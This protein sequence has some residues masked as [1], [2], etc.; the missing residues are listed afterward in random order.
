MTRLTRPAALPVAMVALL[1]AVQPVAAAAAGTQA[2]NQ[3][4]AVLPQPDGVL[5]TLCQIPEA[6]VRLQGQ[7]TGQAQQPYALQ[8]VPT[9]ASCPRRAVFAGVSAQAPAAPGWQPVEQ[10]RVPSARCPGMVLVLQLWQ[11]PGQARRLP[12]DAQGRERVYLEQV[13][14]TPAADSR[15]LLPQ[16]RASWQVQGQCARG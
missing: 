1:M 3:R 8:V 15:A 12:A 14:A 5:H 11:L 6:C 9:T 7:F 2:T 4:P 16:W 13:R 10:L